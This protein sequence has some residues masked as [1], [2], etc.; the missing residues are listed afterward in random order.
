MGQ[1]GF[2][3]HVGKVAALADPIRRA[4]YHFVARQPDAISRDQAAQ[5][6][7]IPR[8]TAK[9]H[10]DKLVDEGLLVTEFKRLTGRSGP[11]AGRPS[12]LYRRARTEVSVSLPRRRYDLASFVLAD[13]VQRALGGSPMPRALREAADQG[14]AAVVDAWGS[15]EGSELARMDGVLNRLG[16]EPRVEGEALS[17]GNCPFAAL[18]EEHEDLVCPLNRQ[19]VQAV[20]RELGC[21]GLRALTVE[22]AIGCCVRVEPSLGGNADE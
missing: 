1:D 3:T 16:Y 8:H 4:L 6:V 14:A 17:L 2:A 5:G 13:A 10:L 7:E 11:G 21:T 18:S 20:G 9:F 15:D 22:S 19:F 12:K